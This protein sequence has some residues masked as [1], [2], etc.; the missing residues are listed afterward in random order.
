MME[1]E[2]R[3][4]FISTEISAVPSG[5]R[6]LIHVVGRNDSNVPQEMGCTWIVKDP[7]GLV[8]ENH[9]DD[10]AGWPV[11]TDV[12]PGATHEFIGSRF[13]INKAGTWTIAIGLFMNSDAPV[14]VDSYSGVLVVIEPLSGSIVKKELEYDGTRGDIPVQ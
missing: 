10:W 4:P 1:A 2:R 13:D 7:Q 5:V 14:Q 3:S 12:N 9:T 6:G 11:P 8:V